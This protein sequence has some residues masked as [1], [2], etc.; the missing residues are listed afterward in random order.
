MSARRSVGLTLLAVFLATWPSRAAA[1]PVP[2]G[3]PA[4]RVEVGVGV[5]VSGSS[6]LGGQNAELTANLNS[7]SFTLFTASASYATPVGVD[8]RITYRLTP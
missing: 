1:Q 5:P 7:S 2:A 8:A 3:G 6:D 4:G